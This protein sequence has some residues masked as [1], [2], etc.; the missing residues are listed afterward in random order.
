MKLSELNVGDNVFV[1]WQRR[2]GDDGDRRTEVLPIAK[3][4]RKYLYIEI[5]R[6][7]TQFDRETGISV[8]KES[9]VRANGMGFDVYQSR[10]AW[11]AQQHAAA[12]ATRLAAR[13]CSR[14]GLNRPLPAETVAAIHAALTSGG[15]PE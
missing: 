15:I 12:E 8:H 10:E 13:M 9:N 6:R 2:R 3:V 11:E 5:H 7:L 14:W 4:G 1:V